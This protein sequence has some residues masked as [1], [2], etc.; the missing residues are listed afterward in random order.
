MKIRFLRTTASASPGYP[1]QAGQ[2]IDVADPTPQM[3]AWLER[4]ADGSQ[5]AEVVRESDGERAVIETGERAV[6]VS[7]SGRR[8]RRG[9]AACAT[10][11]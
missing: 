4:Q 1:F 8:G 7:Q 5:I 2:V 11:D 6:T 9:A 3:L 10:T